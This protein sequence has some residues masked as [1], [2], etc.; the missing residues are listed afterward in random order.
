VQQ[1]LRGEPLQRVVP[2]DWRHDLRLVIREHRLMLSLITA[3]VGVGLLMGVPGVVPGGLDDL[4]QSLFLQISAVAGVILVT[5]ALVGCRLRART[6]E[7]E[8]INGLRGWNAGWAI[9]RR[10]PLSARRLARFLCVL[11][12]IAVLGRA[13]IGWKAAIP[14][15]QP[16][17][18]DV[19]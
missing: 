11:L 12:A 2:A 1:E 18:W 7:G 4:W 15:F 17:V 8:R 13:F 5:L 3:Y 9:A 19:R 10:G 14:E 6:P 16:F